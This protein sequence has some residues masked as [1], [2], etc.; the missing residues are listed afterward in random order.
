MVPLLN[1]A[2]KLLNRDTEKDMILRIF[3]ASVFTSRI[4][5]Q[6]SQARK[7]SGNLEQSILTLSGGVFTLRNI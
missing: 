3:L 7:T 5:F 2:Q 1:R 4:D 6:G